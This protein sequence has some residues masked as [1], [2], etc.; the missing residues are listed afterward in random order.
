LKN[1]AVFPFGT[2]NDL[3]N[4]RICEKTN[5]TLEGLGVD[6]L[7]PFDR[8]SLESAWNIIEIQQPPLS[9]VLV[10]IPDS[11]LN[12]TQQEFVIP[13]VD[14]GLE[15]PSSPADQSAGGHGTGIAGIVGAN[16]VGKLDCS[17]N[18]SSF[19]MTVCLGV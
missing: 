4:L 18:A 2:E 16:N 11:G 5:P 14:T 7:A 8:V 9:A 19:Q 10:G 6:L 17:T 15:T 12:R 13:S 3:T 1:V